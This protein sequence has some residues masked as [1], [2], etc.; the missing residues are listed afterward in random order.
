MFYGVIVLN[1]CD[2]YYEQM[3]QEGANIEIT[4]KLNTF[5]KNF[6]YYI[7]ET[8]KYIEAKDTRKAKYNIQLAKK[9]LE[10]FKNEVKN[11]D[12]DAGSVV[13]GYMVHCAI[14]YGKS[15]P[16][17]L[18]AKGL[19][20]IITNISSKSTPSDNK[21]ISFFTNILNSEL[22]DKLKILGGNIAE[23][24]SWSTKIIGQVK[25]A[26]KIINSLRDGDKTEDA[27]NMYRHDLIEIISFYEKSLDSLESKI[28]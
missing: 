21:L 15:L 11:M 7:N 14:D 9:E 24:V 16:L 12:S 1:E 28:K 25:N 22:G 20:A 27:L 17:M 8:K 6:K 19:G 10:G 18:G 23:L 13:F 26:I 2:L 5:R 3:I 4:K